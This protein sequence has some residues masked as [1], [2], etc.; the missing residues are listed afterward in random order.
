AEVLEPRILLAA[1][2]RLAAGKGLFQLVI[3]VMLFDGNDRTMRFLEHRP[4]P[5]PLA[6]SAFFE[7][8][9]V[10]SRARG[11]IT[12]SSCPRL[13]RA[14]PGHDENSSLDRMCPVIFRV[15]GA[16][17]PACAAAPGEVAGA[18]IAAVADPKQQRAL[19]TIGIFVHLAGRVDD[20]DARRHRNTF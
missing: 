8:G 7:R 14:K 18:H 11:V 1:P 19:R 13:S 6:R 2:P 10:A 5:A 16:L 17:G 9:V 4:S 12:V 20:E 3:P 15:G